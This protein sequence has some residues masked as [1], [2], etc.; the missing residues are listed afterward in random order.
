M[1]YLLNAPLALAAF[2][3]I[4][5]ASLV[6]MQ[7]PWAGWEDGP[8]RG[9]MAYILVVT[10][11]WSLLPLLA[12]ALAAAVFTDAFDR[13]PAFRGRRAALVLGT[14]LA[15]AA[16]AGSMAAA[17]DESRAVNG[18]GFAGLGDP[19][20]AIAAIG[21]TVSPLV[22]VAWLFWLIDAPPRLR[23]AVWPRRAALAALVLT[24]PGFFLG[25]DALLQ[26]IA[27]QG[28]LAAQYRQE[29]DK[30]EA[31]NVAN[32]ASLTDGSPLSS[33]G[34]YATNN[35]YYAER[36]RKA[37]DEMR[38]QALKRIAVRPTLEADLAKDLLSRDL[39]DSFARDSDIAFLL[40]ARAPFAPSAALE[41][42]LRDA[43]KRIAAEMR[44]AGPGKEWPGQSDV[45]DSYISSS[46]AERL[47]ASLPIAERMAAVGVD[48]REA[49]A[50]LGDAALAAYP[51][52]KTA[53]T[54]QKDVAAAEPVVAAT[55][56]AH[57]T[58]K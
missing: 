30:N 41:A 53:L 23:R 58:V 24:A 12:A 17:I 25:A 7:G 38:D 13:P 42:P 51:Q 5:F 14:L 21:G 54:Y 27:A 35:V 57:S 31:E 11:A 22:V 18:H 49:L 8:S 6:L 39:Y 48:L 26:E 28:K 33:W 1:R 44:A 46:F 40:V 15:A 56:G 55:L 16:I 20:G 29:E 52:T 10:A 37:Q 45:L 36:F 19:L 3:Q 50:E 4:A 47:D 2:C 43:M 32:F 9:A 34:A